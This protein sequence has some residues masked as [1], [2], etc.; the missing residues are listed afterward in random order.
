MSVDV[1]NLTDSPAV[2]SLLAA[3]A[4]RALADN[5]SVYVA[6]AAEGEERSAK[7]VART[8]HFLIS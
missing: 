4:L 1:L 2:A 8:A 3:R 7:L 6:V 5:S